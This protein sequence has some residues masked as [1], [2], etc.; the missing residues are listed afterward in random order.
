MTKLEGLMHGKEVGK[1]HDRSDST[2][3][4][5]TLARVIFQNPTWSEPACTSIVTKSTTVHHAKDAMWCWHFE[6]E[7]VKFTGSVTRDSQSE[8]HTL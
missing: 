1:L 3:D 7:D 8:M 6:I 5:L 4:E 2:H